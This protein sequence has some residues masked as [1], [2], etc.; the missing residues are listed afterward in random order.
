MTE[1]LH[2]F[3][4]TR[5]SIRKFTD[6]PVADATV[7]K[8]LETAAYA[9]SAHDRQPWRFAVIQ[10]R[11]ARG[12]LATAVTAKFQ[13]DMVQ[14]GVP[15]SVIRDR[16]ERTLRRTDIAPVIILLC[17]ETTRVDPQPDEAAARVETWMARQSVAAA[18]LQLLLAAHAEGLGGTWICWPIFAPSE[19]CEALDLP[20][21]W[22][23][24]GMIFLGH[25][26]ESPTPPQRIPLEEIVRYI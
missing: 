2:T 11:E 8:I 26:D 16:V 22:E 1:D 6:E 18:G 23:P 14:A 24:Q 3:L 10:S 17:R 19:V 21:E 4:R 13:A 9:P 20:A 12:R 15:E 25:P 7:R 5:R